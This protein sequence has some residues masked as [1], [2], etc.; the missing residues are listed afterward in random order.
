MITLSPSSHTAAGH[1][2][3]HLPPTAM[4]LRRPDDGA[5]D[6]SEAWDPAGSGGWGEYG[7]TH[8]F[9]FLT[10]IG[11]KLYG[12]TQPG[13][14]PVRLLVPPAVCL[15]LAAVFYH[16]ITPFKPQLNDYS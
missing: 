2:F 14:V 1:S 13:A 12:P 10:P 3:A 16:G 6:L 11:I 5:A 15:Y 7:M 4:A 9:K 8:C